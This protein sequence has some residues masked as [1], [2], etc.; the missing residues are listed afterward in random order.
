MK[1]GPQVLRLFFFVLDIRCSIFDVCISDLIIDE[2]HFVSVLTW[3]VQPL[4]GCGKVGCLFYYK[5]VTA[6]RSS[7][8]YC[9][10]CTLITLKVQ[11]LYGG[12]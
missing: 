8:F 5:Y 1:K 7:I 9:V 4:R 6:M 3:I 10:P 11:V 12:R 2:S